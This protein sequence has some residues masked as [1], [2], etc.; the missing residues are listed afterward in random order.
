MR[1]SGI[2]LD[3]L[4][5]S[6]R[7]L[8]ELARYIRNQS[9]RVP[10]KLR[11][12][13]NAALVCQDDDGPQTVRQL[14]TQLFSAV[15]DIP[16]AGVRLNQLGQIAYVPHEAERKLFRGPDASPPLRFEFFIE[17]VQLQG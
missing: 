14:V 16:N 10:D 7:L 1:R 5:G 3:E 12:Q 15:I 8:A 6:S 9:L 4:S 11:L 13:I 2:G 17:R